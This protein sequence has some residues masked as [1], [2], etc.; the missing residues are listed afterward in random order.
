MHDYFL[1][2]SNQLSPEG[3]VA[4]RAEIKRVAR[5]MDIQIETM[6]RVEAIFKAAGQER[7]LPFWLIS[8]CSFLG[9]VRPAD[10]MLS[11]P[12]K[13]VAAAVDEVNGVQH[14]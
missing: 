6:Y 7:F 3:I 9:G 11:D 12:E 14:G 10:M 13:V 2:G 5:Q 8:L 4:F 1:P